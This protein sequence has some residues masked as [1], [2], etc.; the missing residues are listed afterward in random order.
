MERRVWHAH[1]DEGIPVDF[2]FTERTIPEALVL[3]AEK[4]G[5]A[6]ALWYLD[7]RMSWRELEREVARFAAAL[8]GLGVE[9]GTRV[10]M[11]LPNLPQTVIAYQAVLRLGAVAVMTSPLYTGREV[12]HQWN[13]AGC[14]VAIVADFLWMQVVRPVRDRLRV[15]H[16]VTTSVYEYLPFPQ[17]KLA[18][19]KLK[20]T[21]PGMVVDVPREDGVH[22]F[23]ELA[24]QG[25]GLTPAPRPGLDDIA[26]LQY[27]GG[28]TGQA[29]GAVLTHRNLSWNAQGVGAWL[30]IE[31]FADEVVLGALPLFHIFGMTVS[32]NF[33]VWS[34][35]SVVLVPNPRDFTALLETIEKRRVT[36]F[37]GV[38]ALFNGINQH[39]EVA[40]HDL[41]SVKSCFSG[42]APLP[43]DVLERFESLTGSRIVEGFG[44]S[45]TSPNTPVNPLRTVRKIG[46]I[47]VPFVETDAAV[48]D[49][50]TGAMRRPGEDGELV[51]RGPQVMR[52]YWNRPEETA[53]AMRD[54]WFHT[55]DIA[56][57]DEDGYFFISGRLKDMI[58]V[59]GYNVYPDEV[60][61]V[62]IAHPA[63]AESG[64]IGVPDPGCGERVRSY[65][66]L[67]A[68]AKATRGELITHCRASLAR[69]KV[70]REIVFRD[71][72]PR[73]G[74]LKVLRRELR[75]QAIA[76][77]AA[78]KA[79]SEDE[80]VEAP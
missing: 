17:N 32:M 54:G 55:G 44:L 50:E 62:L 31:G 65:V 14:E 23:G 7:R 77:A 52:G 73:N 35:C 76:E 58:I 63:V 74:A 40:R 48:L 78:G 60:D 42:S 30:H 24:K 69:Y 21:R 18:P 47:G 6:P 67:K 11:M 16:V 2:R 25:R 39:P 43:I 70:P 51:I 75:D 15:R 1:Y 8:M 19:I 3:A 4:R 49:P 61:A 12:E 72:L 64:T 33:P 46:S 26:A 59:S 66:V 57:M 20:R 10:A 36:L 68:D 53:V 27:T 22:R 29:K 79:R 38:P 13:D 45:E 5:D 71:E 80:L 9:R 37:M 56:R 34:A 41:K 28:T